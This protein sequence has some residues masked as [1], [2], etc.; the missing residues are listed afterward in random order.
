MQHLDDGVLAAILDGESDGQTVRRSDGRQ[1][2]AECAECQERLEAMRVTRERARAILRMGTPSGSQPSFQE[3]LRRRQAKTTD[4]KRL[5]NLR[6]LA[7][8]AS[9]VL[10]LSVGWYT[11]ELQLRPS[12]PPE[13]LLSA[14]EMDTPVVADRAVATQSPPPVMRAREE[15]ALR[16][17]L[18][19]VVV[20][21]TATGEPT[22]A[23]ASVAEKKDEPVVVAAA[24]D[25]RLKKV[26]TPQVAL[27]AV[28]AREQGA[29]SGA[30]A[31]AQA[32]AAARTEMRRM[33]APVAAPS[34]QSAAVAEW[35]LVDLSQ[36]TRTLG[37]PPLTV[38]GLEILE[39]QVSAGAVRVHQ[40]MQTGVL[41]LIQQHAGPGV[42]IT[43]LG[44]N[45]LVEGIQVKLWGPVSYDSLRALVGKLQ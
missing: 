42:A 4:A 13:V 36:A 26:N 45:G 21:S 22:Q 5:A 7:W 2:L 34:V 37:R 12:A 19:D 28:V 8:A 32:P 14:R 18:K 35:T 9:I 27:D 29:V 3:I 10:A 30:V 24:D 38:P 44:V 11:R 15:P 6:P 20:T 16:H 17:D 1:H 33:A 23:K 43:G 41:D 40:R 31:N 25:A 39:Y